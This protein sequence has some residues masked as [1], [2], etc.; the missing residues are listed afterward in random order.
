VYITIDVECSMG[1]AWNDP[2]LRPVPP[3]RGV[4]G[5]Y[6]RREYG[7]GL[8]VKTLRRYDLAGTFFVEPFNTELGYDDH[9]TAEICRYLI[10]Q[11]Q[12]VQLHV[13]PGH[14]H[15]GLARQGRDHPHTDQLAKL[16]PEAQ[17]RMLLDGAGRIERWTGTRPLAFRAGNMGAS[18]ACLEHIA[19]A[20]MVL[21]SSY[22]FPFAGGQCGFSPRGPYNGSRRFES[23]LELALSGF[24]QIPL[25]G[26]RQA[27]VLD[28]VGVSF[29]ECRDAIRTINAA[30]VEAVAILHSFSLMKV[31]NK[32]YDGG[33]PNRVIHRRFE[34]LCRY[35]AAHRDDHPVRTVGHL[36]RQWQ[37]GQFTPRSAPP[38]R[39]NRP[40]RAVVRKAVQAVN[41]LYWV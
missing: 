4:W 22:C 10:D 25:P 31:R 29:G 8:I 23:V 26:M 6:G 16:P 2:D 17:R 18:E 39:I 38:P 14:V 13:H 3:E 12:D 1:G 20:G 19:A 5:R 11:G 27:K 28:P 7:I 36:A 21:D 41:S 37:A 34:K 40:A 30:G 15:Y 35:L 24:Y 32:Q 9:Q 33:R